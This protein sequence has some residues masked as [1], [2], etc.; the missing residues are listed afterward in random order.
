MRSHSNHNDQKENEKSPGSRLAHMELCDINDTA[1]T[2]AGL[3]ILNK[4]R[5]HTDRQARAL[6]KQI[7]EQREY[8]SKEI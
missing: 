7:N 8:F 1:F 2:I 5:Q 3:K 4:V 6:R